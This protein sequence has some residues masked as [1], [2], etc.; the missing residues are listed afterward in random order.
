MGEPRTTALSP[1]RLHETSFEGMGFVPVSALGK[2]FD[3]GQAM[4]FPWLSLSVC[5]F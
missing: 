5:D 3:T 2:L 1:C 4:Y